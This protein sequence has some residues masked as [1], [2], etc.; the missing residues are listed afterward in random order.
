MTLN[1]KPQA[2]DDLD[3]EELEDEILVY[4][5]ESEKTYNFNG[6]GAFVWSLCDGDHTLETMVRGID[7]VADGTERETIE[8]DV[9]DFVEE[10]VEDG[11]LTLPDE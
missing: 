4:D 1:T 2:R 8:R 7:N 10:L 3:V 5:P 6:T 11:L 9:L